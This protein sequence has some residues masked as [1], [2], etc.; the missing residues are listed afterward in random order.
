MR[1]VTWCPHLQLRQRL[2]VVGLLG[3]RSRKAQRLALD[4][5]R[6]STEGQ[7]QATGPRPA[8]GQQ[9]DAS[10]SADGGTG[11]EPRRDRDRPQPDRRTAARHRAVGGRGQRWT[12]GRGQRRRLTEE[13][14][15]LVEGTG[16]LALWH[17]GGRRLT[18]NREGL[19]AEG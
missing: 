19:R 3:R 6:R 2:V 16:S 17:S 1:E 10:A 5:R 15:P 7:G 12:A 4:G 18:E 11:A 13:G 8:G 9:L 14:W